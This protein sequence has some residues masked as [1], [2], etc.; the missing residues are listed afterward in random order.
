MRSKPAWKYRD[1]GL[2]P[3]WGSYDAIVIGGGITGAAAA[4]TMAEQR[5]RVALLEPTGTLG[6]EVTRAYNG[7]V[8]LSDY[9]KESASIAA[10]YSLLDERKGVFGDQIAAT[11]A[12]IAFDEL[13]APYPVDVLFHVWPSR[14]LTKASKAAGLQVSCRSG[15]AL[16]DAPTVIDASAHGKIGKQWFTATPVE[17]GTTSIQLLYNGVIGEC[18]D[19]IAASLPQAGELRVRCRPTYWPQE[20]RVTL[21]TNGYR[22]RADWQLL[23]DEII[24]V[25]RERIPALQSGVLAHMSDDVWGE[26]R[27]R[28]STASADEQIAGYWIQTK[29]HAR[30]TPSIPITRGDLCNPSVMDGLYVAGPWL[31][32]YPF[33]ADDEQSAIVNAFL[34]GDT[35][36]RAAMHVM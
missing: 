2:T 30:S 8:K 33:D 28:I 22:I 18:P 35:V 26:P 31:E 3:H 9:V 17:R 24:A 7:F 21:T 19:E 6:R 12:G 27:L 32:R 36:G 1:R 5:L 23:L 25:L 11:V 20:W 15:G 29:G 16:L 14:L 10:F 4:R 13:L 34:L